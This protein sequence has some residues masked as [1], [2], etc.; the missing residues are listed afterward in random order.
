LYI[1]QISLP[2]H[3]LDTERFAR[4]WT[5]VIEREDILRTSFHWQDGLSVPVQI[6]HRHVELPLQ[7]EDWLLEAWPYVCFV[8]QAGITSSLFL[9]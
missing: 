2:V 1:N 9:Q 6:V 5:S 8:G 3:G 7:I 4:A